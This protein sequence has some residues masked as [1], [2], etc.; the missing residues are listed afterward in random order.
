MKRSNSK[1]TL[2][3]PPFP[4]TVEAY[5]THLWTCRNVVGPTTFVLEPT[6]QQPW[7]AMRGGAWHLKLLDTKHRRPRKTSPSDK[8]GTIQRKLLRKNDTHKSRSVPSLSH[9]RV[10]FFPHKSHL[11][12]HRGPTGSRFPT[13]VPSGLSPHPIFC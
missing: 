2:G 8:V 7:H 1:S 13:Q 4:E 3:P 9:H 10:P 5:Q 6:G 12:C 11:G